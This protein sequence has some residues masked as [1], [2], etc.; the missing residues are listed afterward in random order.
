MCAGDKKCTKCSVAGIGRISKSKSISKMRR[1]SNQKTLITKVAGGAAGFIGGRFLNGIDFVGANP[2]IGGGAKIA[3][4]VVL[5]S[6]KKG[7]DMVQSAGVGLGVA[8]VVDLVDHFVPGL[9]DAAPISGF[10]LD[11]NPNQV[12]G[13][14]QYNDMK[15]HV[16]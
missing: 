12:A 16:S 8:G 6:M 3:I 9:G 11:R 5:A 7:G 13:M 4:G 2:L 14:P 15:L 10:L 1:G